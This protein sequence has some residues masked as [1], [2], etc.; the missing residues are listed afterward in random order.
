M[1]L[2]FLLL[3]L[4]VAFLL[5][6]ALAL[7]WA[8]RHRK[9][10]Q[11]RAT[12]AQREAQYATAGD[13]P[14]TYVEYR[15]SIAQSRLQGLV[16]DL[17]ELGMP[18]SPDEQYNEPAIRF[19]AGQV[20]ADKQVQ[21]L[22][23]ARAMLISAMDGWLLRITTFKVLA[24]R[25]DPPTL[26]EL[27]VLFGQGPDPDGD[28]ARVRRFAS[29]THGPGWKVCAGCGHFLLDHK[30]AGGCVTPGATSGETVAR[31]FNAQPG[32]P[33][34][35]PCGCEVAGYAD[36]IVPTPLPKTGR[37]GRRGRGR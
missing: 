18:Y 23:R 25:P 26:D 21:R 29:D 9:R 6:I 5:L 17:K 1:R 32:A 10:Q 34:V 30:Q 11:R 15:G 12:I 22:D 36:V 14:E 37:G 24:E 31:T 33:F 4:F 35:E 2:T 19:H 20:R 7:R 27:L 3:M 28:Y 13:V 16:E 8:L